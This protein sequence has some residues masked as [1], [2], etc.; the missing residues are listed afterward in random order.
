MTL[1]MAPVHF[2]PAVFISIPAF[3]WLLETETRKLRSFLAGWAFGAGY[4]IFGFYWISAALFVDIGQWFWVLPFSLIVG[5]GLFGLYWGFPALASHFFKSNSTKHAVIFVTALAVTEYARGFLM[6]G[7]PWNLPGQAWGWVPV[8]EQAASIGS[9]YFLTLLTLFWAAVPIYYKNRI[10]LFLAVFSF[11]AVL[12]Y[13]SVRMLDYTP[14]PTTTVVRI[15]QPNIPQGQKWDPDKEWKNFEDTVRQMSKT[16]TWKPS[17]FVLPETAIR[18]DLSTFPDITRFIARH[19]PKESVMIAGNLRVTETNGKMQFYNSVEM[20][21]DKA[22][23]LA[24]YDKHHLVPFGEFIPF[25]DKIGIKPIAAAVS[26]IGDFTRGSGPAT[27]KANG[28]PAFSPLICYE[29]LF[30][31]EAVNKN[32]R[33]EWIVNSTNDAW[34]GNS[35]GPYQHLDTTRM[36]AIEH[37]LP[38]A[39]AANTGISAMIDPM[40]RVI[41][42]KPLMTT[43]FVDAYLPQSL[44]PTLY[45]RFGDLIFA[46]GLFILILPLLRR[47]H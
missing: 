44:P 34:Y 45:D 37:G 38:V 27:I 41:D 16:S 29:V 32:E 39:R 6:T 15:I 40:G 12:S 5:P 30:P 24:T 20:M 43:G 1:A 10:Y 11:A 7:F 17:V 4:F 33:P 46:L 18:A 47:S 25:R 31:N 28:A 19:M 3:I 35:S 14:A 22:E 8:I 26:G 42:S 36:R 2:F 9:I 23:V 13:G 21:N